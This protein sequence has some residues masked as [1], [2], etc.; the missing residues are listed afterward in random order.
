MCYTDGSKM[1]RDGQKLAFIRYLKT[2]LF[3]CQV[4]VIAIKICCNLTEIS[5]LVAQ[6]IYCSD[7]Q[8]AHRA[9]DSCS[10][11]SG[12]L[13]E[14]RDALKWADRTHVSR[15]AFGIRSLRC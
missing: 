2:V 1:E 15:A 5:D 11:A 3:W 6:C 9:F 8:A 4:K 10:V 12:I 13:G 7:S 14:C